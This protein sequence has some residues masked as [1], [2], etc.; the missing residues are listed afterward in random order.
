MVLL[1][2]Y[3]SQESV[4]SLLFPPFTLRWYEM[5]CLMLKDTTHGIELQTFSQ[6]TFIPSE[7]VM[8]AQD[9]TPSTYPL[10][11]ADNSTVFNEKTES[12]N[13]L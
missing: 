11:Y 4:V 5:S 9:K 10:R 13:S 12:L 2:P 7:Y 3:N 8:T 1:P 6:P